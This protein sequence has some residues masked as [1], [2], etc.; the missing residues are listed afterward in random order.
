MTSTATKA[1]LADSCATLL[2][3]GSF[4]IQKLGHRDVEQ[5]EEGSR[6]HLKSPRWWLGFL[7]MATGICIHIVALPYADMT[8]LA[9]N[10]SLAIMGNLILSMYLF[11]EKWVWKYDCTALILICAGCF[12]IALM[13]DKSQKDYDGAM[14]LDKLRAPIAIAFYCFVFS[15]MALTMYVMKLFEKA[16]R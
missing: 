3:N 11:D 4:S 10:S 2:I 12:S 13:A 8:L 14:L 1:F 7:I 16:L 5:A 6:A 15:L 9:A